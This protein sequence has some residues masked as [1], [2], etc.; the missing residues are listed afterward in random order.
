MAS[1]YAPESWC[2]SPWII[3]NHNSRV[4]ASFD[5]KSDRDAI[6]RIAR[7]HD[8]LV[9]ALEEC[10]DDLESEINARAAGELPRRISRD[11]EAVVRARAAL[12]LA[13]GKE[14]V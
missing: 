12:V 9:R 2:G 4:V 10:A 8:A 11:M 13:K 1:W 14:N 5:Y 7:A 6:L 3:S